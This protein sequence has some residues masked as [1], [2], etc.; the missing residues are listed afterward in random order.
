MC[1]RD[2]WCGRNEGRW[3]KLWK[4]Q[5]HVPLMYAVTSVP[6]G[7]VTSFPCMRRK[8]GAAG[9][10][11]KLVATMPPAFLTQGCLSG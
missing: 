7:M 8:T 6:L 9:H 11:I 10:T 2:W 3:L 1:G 4:V 5:L